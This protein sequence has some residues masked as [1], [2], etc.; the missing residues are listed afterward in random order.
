MEISNPVV[1]IDRVEPA[2]IEKEVPFKAKWTVEADAD[3]EVGT[4]HV[5]FLTDDARLLLCDS[6]T[7]ESPAEDTVQ[8]QPGARVTGLRLR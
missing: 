6:R 5:T 2:V 7:E 8:V 1:R 3:N 4:F